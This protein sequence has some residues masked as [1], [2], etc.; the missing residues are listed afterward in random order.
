MPSQSYEGPVSRYLNR[1]LSRTAAAALAHTA[2]TPNQVSLFA[3]ATAGAAFALF[4]GGWNIAAGLVVHA[5][6]V[7]DGIDGDLARAKRMTST[8]GG[9]F[10]AALDRWADVLIF[11]GMAL[12]AAEHEGWELAPVAGF[13]AVVGSLLVSYSRARIEASTDAQATDLLFGLASRDVRL[14]I[15]A[16]GAIIGLAYFTLW[17]IAIATLLT[18]CWRL[19]S[20]PRALS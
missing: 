1:P 8:F 18:V 14:F 13:L 4:A 3:L 5:S 16:I 6:S 19:V 9:V 11:S 7:I 12:W 2:V 10:D 15:A 17:I 20:L